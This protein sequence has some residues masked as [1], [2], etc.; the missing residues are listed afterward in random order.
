MPESPFFGWTQLFR[1]TSF[2]LRRPHKR[3]LY[4]E[5]FLRFGLARKGKTGP[6]NLPDPQR[7]VLLFIATRHGQTA[8]QIA[9][10]VHD[11]VN[12]IEAQLR[13]L[14]LEIKNE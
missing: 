1:N 11:D 2:V 9:A 14:G 4:S 10:L 13:S 3:M 5:D 8:G 6:A 12:V 7:V